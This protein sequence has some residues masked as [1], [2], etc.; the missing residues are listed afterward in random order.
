MV[1][2][3]SDQAGLSLCWSGSVSKFEHMWS[4]EIGSSF[5]SV[6]LILILYHFYV[7]SELQERR[8]SVEIIPL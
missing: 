2:E 5:K 1:C 7:N 3:S 8:W 4:S 6:L